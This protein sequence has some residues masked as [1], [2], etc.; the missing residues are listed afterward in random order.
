MPLS[1]RG[2]CII[3]DCLS[4]FVS[5]CLWNQHP[6][7]FASL[8]LISLLHLH[9]FLHIL[10]RCFYLHHPSLFPSSVPG[11]ILSCPINHSHHG[12]LVPIRLLPWTLRPFLCASAM[13]KHILAI[14]WTSVRP[15]V[16]PSLCLSHAG[17]VS[18]RLNILSCFLHHTIPHSF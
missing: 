14:G 4:W 2:R 17:I 15:S 6:H 13:L 8:I 3:T 10:V 7:Y 9:I 16:C 1:Y 11:L 5:S 12:L 18:K